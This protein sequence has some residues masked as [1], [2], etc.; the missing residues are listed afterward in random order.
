[1]RGGACAQ[2]L[3][4]VDPID[5]YAVQQMKEYDGK[6]LVS[7]TKEGL[8]FDETDEEKAKREEIMASYEPLCR[9]MKD[10]LGD[11]VEKVRC[12]PWTPLVGPRP[13]MP[14]HASSGRLAN[15]KTCARRCL[16]GTVS[17][18]PAAA[19]GLCPLNIHP[20]RHSDI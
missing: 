12:I 1:M 10:I 19:G 9:L 16:W 15:S 3:F 17:S 2:V 7:V 20:R 14:G 4:L 6:K 8:K 5:E 13:R 11:K 18:S